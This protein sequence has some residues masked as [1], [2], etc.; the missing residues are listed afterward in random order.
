MKLSTA[1]FGSVVAICCTVSLVS[2]QVKFADGTEQTTAFTGLTT[3][4]SG[5]AFHVYIPS[6]GVVGSR[7]QLSD[8][9]PTG[10]ELVILQAYEAI[11]SVFNEGPKFAYLSSRID[12]IE[13]KY[14][15]SFRQVSQETPDFSGNNYPDG[16][17]IVDEG[18]ELWLE[19]NDSDTEDSRPYPLHGGVRVLGY[20]RDK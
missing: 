10:Q 2:G 16:T 8:P 7:Y 18:E 4:P 20:Y 15:T 9:V 6:S 13:P 3:V 14:L 1:L 12:G 5:K 17:F 19:S 11:S